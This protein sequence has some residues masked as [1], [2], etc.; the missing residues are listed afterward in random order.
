MIG[1]P[2][3]TVKRKSTK[4][5]NMGL[6]KN[7]EQ[8]AAKKLQ[9]LF[10][11]ANKYA[12]SAVNDVERAEKALEDA[13]IKALEATQRAHEAAVEAATKAQKVADDLA[14]E[15]RAAA[16]RASYHREQ[17]NQS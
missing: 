3:T 11:D 16:E 10:L 5:S 4:E 2:G 1:L 14:L 6:L 7:L 9:K 13:K 17:A 12:E 15:A 8:I